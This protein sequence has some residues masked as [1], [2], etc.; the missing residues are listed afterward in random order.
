MIRSIPEECVVYVDE[1]GIDQYLHRPHA[2][3]PR[4]Q[5]AF[6][7]ASGKRYK[8]TSIVAGLCMKS[9]T[10]PLQYDGTMDSALFEFWFETMLL[11][12]LEPGGVIV[13][14]NARFHR[15]SVLSVLADRAGCYV[16]F[17]PPY[18]PDLNLI[19]NFWAWLKTRLRKILPICNSLDD[20]ISDCFK[21][22]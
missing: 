3:S 8:R 12:S 10:A 18:S 7:E 11:P 9:I 14:D 20:A 4:G 19:E 1:T 16:L 6:G 22:V 15:K 2:R 17:L 21:L 5:P 13:M